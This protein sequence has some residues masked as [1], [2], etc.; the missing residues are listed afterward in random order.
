V[1]LRHETTK[2][3]VNATLE[4]IEA[5]INAATERNEL[6][7]LSDLRTVLE[8]CKNGTSCLPPTVSALL[9]DARERL[10]LKR[11]L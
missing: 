2:E 6:E 10:N 9:T 5:R 3:R 4:S 1:A 8:W 11:H 7:F